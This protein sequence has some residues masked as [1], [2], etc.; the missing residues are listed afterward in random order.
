MGIVEDKCS[1]IVKPS[2][3]LTEY[4]KKIED[5]LS[6]CQPENINYTYSISVSSKGVIT[7]AKTTKI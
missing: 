5:G 4:E 7:L 1:E 2:H 6:K 3:E